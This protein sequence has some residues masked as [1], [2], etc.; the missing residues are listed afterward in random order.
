MTTYELHEFLRRRYVSAVALLLRHG[1]TSLG[2]VRLR[3]AS[4]VDPQLGKTVRPSQ[5][6]DRPPIG[7]AGR[8][9]IAN[10]NAAAAHDVV[11]G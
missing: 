11:P 4:A 9:F 1:A 6:F 2:P 3:W 10:I 7:F 8:P 5:A